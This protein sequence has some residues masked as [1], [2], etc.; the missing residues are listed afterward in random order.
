M[1]VDLDDVNLENLPVDF[2]F[3]D[4]LAFPARW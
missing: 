3:R 1:P 2:K 4:R